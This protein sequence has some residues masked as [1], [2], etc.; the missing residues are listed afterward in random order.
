MIAP[1]E[2]R[3]RRFAVGKAG[4]EARGGAFRNMQRFPVHGKRGRERQRE[5]VFRVQKKLILRRER[6]AVVVF[7]R[8][9]PFLHERAQLVRACAHAE[10]DREPLPAHVCRG[11]E[12]VPADPVE[13]LFE[14]EF[15]VEASARA[16]RKKKAAV[17]GLALREPW[18]RL[19]GGR[20]A[21]LKRAQIAPR[22]RH[23]R[24]PHAPRKLGK[25]GLL[26]V[27]RRVFIQKRGKLCFVPLPALLQHGRVAAGEQKAQEILEAF[28]D[29]M[30]AFRRGVHGAHGENA[31]IGAADGAIVNAV[32]ARPAEDARA[33]RR[34]E[35]RRCV[36]AKLEAERRKIDAR[37]RGNF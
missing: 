32:H 15:R 10:I 4:M 1:P 19:F 24:E 21:C 34:A 37:A 28:G 16:G 29:G 36:R 7:G 20:E 5:R 6:R 22:L 33:F 31:A 9:L 27:R 35:I 18:G 23:G 25:R 2:G 3:E 30:N 17:E 14:R 12:P 11:H 8:Q 13:G 26:L